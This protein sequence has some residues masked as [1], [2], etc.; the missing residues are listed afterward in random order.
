MAD[1]RRPASRIHQDSARL[2]EGFARRRDDPAFFGAKGLDPAVVPSIVARAHRDNLR[3]FA[4]KAR[5][6]STLRWTPAS[7]WSRT[8]PEI[9]TRR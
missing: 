8:C 6:I 7:M 9:C 1:H 4:W 5:T 2:S 3:V